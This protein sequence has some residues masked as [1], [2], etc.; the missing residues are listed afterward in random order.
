ME[1]KVLT[2]KEVAEYL[3]VHVDVVFRMVRLNPYFDIF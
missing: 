3:G 1:K 2:V